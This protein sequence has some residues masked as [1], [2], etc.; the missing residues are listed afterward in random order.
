MI[1]LWTWALDNAPDGDMSS[2]PP[3][4][5]AFGAAWRGDPVVFVEAAI[6][7]GWLD[8][9][10]DKL[11]IHDWNDYAGRLIEKRRHDAERKRQWRGQNNDV[12]R[13]SFGHDV[14][15]TC[16]GAGTVP[17]LTV[18]NL[19]NNLNKKHMPPSPVGVGVCET[20]LTEILEQALEQASQQRDCAKTAPVKKT[21]PTVGKATDEYSPE[22]EDF[23]K[24]YPRHEEKKNAFKAWKTRL[25]EGRTAE[26]IKTAAQNYAA[27]V[28]ANVSE[29]RYVKQPKTFLGPGDHIREWLKPPEPQQK[30]GQSCESKQHPAV[31]DPNSA[32]F[33]KSRTT[34]PD[35]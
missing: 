3:R 9:E 14:D 7:S 26:E 32:W 29:T 10:G 17:N 27:Y 21:A 8:R 6:R 19:T 28:M 12:R 22:F 13:T 18:P 24:I 25:K 5:I 15:G 11:I 2:L 16:D 33:R 30:G 1:R 23:W 35:V 31:P 34:T 20:E 4:V